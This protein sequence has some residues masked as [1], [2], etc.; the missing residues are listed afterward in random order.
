M[1]EP[2]NDF[3]NLPDG[4]ATL[5]DA[6]RRFAP[7][8]LLREHDQALEAFERFRSRTLR[9]S[10][11][12]D[13]P[14]ADWSKADRLRKSAAEA[15]WKLKQKRVTDA[16]FARL[17]DGELTALVQADAPF[18]L[19]RP[20]PPSSWEH[21]KVK[22]YNEGRVTG[23][24]INLSGVHVIEAR[25]TDLTR[26]S[27]SGVPGRRSSADLM[28]EEFE[29][30]VAAREVANKI[31]EEAKYLSEWVKSEYPTHPSMTPKT[32]A[33]RIRQEF[34]EYHSRISPSRK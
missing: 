4:A 21:L 29:R 1:A 34:I 26:P 23:P 12:V 27:K 17:K 32:V 8:E 31:G 2:S 6:I 30:R 5:Y 13:G 16:F 14:K 24:G 25:F 28:F 33:N 3:Y 10:S 15:N 9:I 22:S 7:E 20:M 11:Y 18:G 19:W